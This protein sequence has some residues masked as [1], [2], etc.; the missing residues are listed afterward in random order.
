MATMEEKLSVV[1]DADTTDLQS[2]MRKA[3]REVETFADKSEN[4]LED[5]ERA[6]RDAKAATAT[7][8]ASMAAAM[9]GVGASILSLVESSA[10]FRQEQARLVASFEG[11]GGSATDAMN[12]FEDLYFLMG[13]TGAATE[14]TQLLSQITTDAQELDEWVTVLTGSWASF[15]ESIPIESLIEA[16]NEAIKTGDAVSGLADYLNWI[17][18]SGIDIAWVFSGN[19]EAMQAFQ[20]A[21]DAG[22]TPAEA[23]TAALKEMATAEERAEAIQRVMT[24]GTGKQGAAFTKATRDLKAYNS[25]QLRWEEAVAGIATELTP[26]ATAILNFGAAI[27]E[28]MKGPMS[29]V[30]DFIVDDFIPALDDIYNWCKNNSDVVTAAISAI[31]GAFAGF[32]TYGLVAALAGVG[33]G[34][35]VMARNSS[36]AQRAMVGLSGGGKDAAAHLANAGIALTKFKHPIALAAAAVVGLS[37]AMIGF[38][39]ATKDSWEPTQHLTDAQLELIRTSAALGDEWDGMMNSYVE[40]E[41]FYTTQQQYY[42]DLADELMTLADASGHVQEKDKSRVNF[43]L[44]ELSQA[45]GTEYKLIGNQIQG[46]EDLAQSIQGVI[47]KKAAE[48]LL[49]AREET[50]VQAIQNRATAWDALTLAQT[51]YEAQAALVAQKE[52]ERAAAQAEYQAAYEEWANNG[53]HRSMV[54]E[55]SSASERLTAITSDLEKEKGVLAEKKEAYD[56]A[57]ADY[58]QYHDEIAI[59][60]EASAALLEGNVD[61]ALQLLS[62]ERAGWA[63]YTSDVVSEYRTNISELERMAVDT[64]LEAERIRTNFENGVDGY[65]EEMVREAES[66]HEQ[67]LAELQKA[68]LEAHQAGVDVGYGF[69]DGTTA[70]DVLA[71]VRSKASNLVATAIAAMRAAADSH[72][73]SRKTMALGNDMGEGVE[74]GLDEKA[75]DVASSAGKMIQEAI[76]PIEANVRSVSYSDF[77]GT[78][79]ASLSSLNSMESRNYQMVEALV[80]KLITDKSTSTPI[81]LQVDGKTFAQTTISTVNKL[82]HDTG[83]LGLKIM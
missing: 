20:E 47:D 17:D 34:L 52:A 21:I 83:S 30:S 63:N 18:W 66:A 78:L 38:N 24:Q 19:A 55:V 12:V 46:Y 59:Y 62:T 23:F 56:T 50:Y 4:A 32:K 80:N 14:A 10:Q 42:Q 67:S 25:A 36:I 6:M 51:D 77:S 76:V 49:E 9:V 39:Q 82:T 60:E 54:S 48:L 45:Y 33:Q 74:I 37:A 41:S 64:G 2:D 75:K 58:G 72:S 26:A 65:T 3:R 8:T 70:A 40:N 11:V 28:D 81:V 15:G 57:A 69:S 16:S 44:H 35:T 29:E 43:I 22:L 1:V 71:A 31:V 79:G 5:Y 53:F 73:P 61:R 13:D 68:V 27:L 7:A